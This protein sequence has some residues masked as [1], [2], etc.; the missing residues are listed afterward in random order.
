M[1]GRA[2][3]TVTPSSSASSRLSPVK[4]SSP[5]GE[6]AAG[7]LPAPGHVAAAR[8]LRDQDPAVRVGNGAGDDMDLGRVFHP[9]PPR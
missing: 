7:E 1:S 8:A 2:A 5:D 3:R 4:G 6:L 9:W